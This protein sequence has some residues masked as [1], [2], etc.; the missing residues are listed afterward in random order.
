M[1]RDADEQQREECGGKE[2][3]SG[4]KDI[5]PVEFN[6]DAGRNSRSFQRKPRPRNPGVSRSR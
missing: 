2:D 3:A 4:D 5:V 1:A 6:G